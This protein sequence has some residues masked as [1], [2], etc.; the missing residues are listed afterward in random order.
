MT[1]VQRQTA[2]LLDGAIAGSAS[3]TVREHDSR[4]CLICGSRF[5][6]FGFGP[7]LTRREVWA[8]SLHRAEVDRQVHPSHSVSAAAETS[9]EPRETQE[10]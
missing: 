7:P 1:T 6:L 5:P 2:M 3:D 4:R 9:R 10:K 8:C